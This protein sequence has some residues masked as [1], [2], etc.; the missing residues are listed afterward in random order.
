M[1]AAAFLR[2]QSAARSPHTQVSISF[3]E[4]VDAGALQAAWDT[5]CAIHP[6][7]RTTFS[8]SP[9]GDVT[10]LVSQR[11][12]TTWRETDW[13]GEVPDSLSDK[14]TALRSADAL[15]AMEAGANMR[16]S[17]ILLPTGGTHYL[18]TYP[19]YLLDE[20]SLAGVLLDWLVALEREPARRPE[21][22]ARLASAS[23]W[24]ELLKSSEGPLVL[25]PM[26]AGPAPLTASHTLSRDETLAFY[27]ACSA[28][29]LEPAAV[30]GALWALALRRL[31]ATGNT[32]LECVNAR[33]SGGEAGYFDNW[34]PCPQFSDSKDWLA[35]AEARHAAL[36]ANAWISP[37]SALNGAPS[38][39]GWEAFE[40]G[41]AWRGPDVNDVIHTAL[42]RW[43]NFDARVHPPSPELLLL[44]AR[45][46]SR[47]VLNLR[48]R[49]ATAEQAAD[50]L[51]RV[52]H[53]IT[54]VE[55][56]DG[57]PLRQIPLLA[58]QEARALKEWSRGPEGLQRPTSIPAA[59]KKTVEHHAANIAVRDGDYELP[60]AELDALSDRLAA[61]F[62]HASVAGGWNVALFLSPSSWIAISLLACWKAG[63]T[64]LPL[65]PASPPQW[66][67]SLLASHDVG[68]VICDAAS[69]PLL[70]ASTRRRIIL[71]QEW[72]TL[73]TSETPSP[74]LTPDSPA[75]IL[76]GHADA[77]PPALRALT[78]EMLLT[79]ALEG[80][81]ILEFGPTHS[82]LAHSV[83]G[84][85]AFFD[86][87][88]LPML[89]GGTVQI[90]DDDL[91]DPVTAKSTHLRLTSSEWNN[92]A[93]RWASGD[94]TVESPLQ[95]VAVEAGTASTLALR[96]W[97]HQT[98]VRAVSFFSVAGLCGLGLAAPAS[99]QGLIIPAGTP[100]PDLEAAV[101]D[102]DGH[103]LLP[104]YL[105]SLCMKF[106][107]WKRTSGPHGRRGLET[108]IK[109]WRTGS[110][111]ISIRPESL[112]ARDMELRA[113]P[114]V[115]DAFVADCAW[116]LSPE[117]VPGAITLAEWPLT[118]SGS[119]DP[120]AL[121]RPETAAAKTPSQAVPK[122]QPQ[123]A[124]GPWKPVSVLQSK[125]PGTPLV[126][127]P[128]AAGRAEAY[129]DLVSALGNTRRILG[130]TAR[131]AHDPEAA[132]KTIE[133]A[134]AAWIDALLEED[135]TLGFDLCG[136]GFGGVVALEMARQLASAKRSVPGLTLIGTPPPQV[137]RPVGWLASVKN[138]FKRLNSDEPLEPFDLDVE[139]SRTHDGAWQRYRFVPADL[140]ATII[141]PSDFALDAPAAWLALLPSARIE[142]VKCAWA[143]MLRF[144]AVKRLASILGD[145]P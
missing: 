79:A 54:S 28:R 81:R 95:V 6:I 56:F 142:P 10:A 50:I 117:S 105:G 89:A 140:R 15:E 2:D 99:T 137:E 40:T 129:G 120:D 138:V 90:A 32:I 82:L 22:P 26:P 133:S 23:A 98:S 127:V 19:A 84:G 123:K 76:P 3:G 55:S 125:G 7:L 107:G 64:C 134:A 113:M 44:E 30:T 42:P 135:P 24:Q 109:A 41:F 75:A 11:S 53:L 1:Q 100:T 70:D 92:Q 37:S 88:L 12:L 111:L 59:F 61:H 51:A 108:S 46:A 130:L 101:T 13:R 57:K 21:V 66:I 47:L 102:R 145:Q 20:G 43:I 132:H 14:W 69:A 91:L 18:L 83:A 35:D 86:E 65:D 60:F 17:A 112:T 93:A 103:D 78:H 48:G 141:I 39:I 80:A 38:P 72:E 124:D 139:P 68:V 114:G 29:N 74:D 119:L 116:V 36:R 31:G 96:I 122:P 9:I 97:Q 73:E 115:I 106:P 33:P 128:P 131:G 16:I 85:G 58:P 144:P 49:L 104:G 110:G 8:R 52:A 126:L 25:H 27:E 143:E 87:W 118:Q 63:N 71:D 121:P 67:E 77:P 4:Q 136:F 5:V 94:H 34:L 62:A 45:P